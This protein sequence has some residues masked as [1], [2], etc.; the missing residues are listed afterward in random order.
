LKKSSSSPSV[1]GL[2]F[3]EVIDSSKSKSSDVGFDSGFEE[4]KFLKIN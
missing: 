3:D 4:T 1:D 2:E